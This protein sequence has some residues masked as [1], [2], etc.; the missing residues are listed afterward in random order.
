MLLLDHAA[1]LTHE[2]AKRHL[3]FP[4]EVPPG[5]ARLRIDMQYAPRKVEGQVATN[6]LSLTLFDPNGARGAGHHRLDHRVE[7]SAAAATPGY[8]PG[9]L[10]VGRWLVVVDTHMI[11]PGPVVEMRLT[12]EVSFEPVAAP[13]PSPAPRR[14][15]GR[16]PGWYRGDLHGHTFH[17]DG[18]W[19]V[20]DLVAAARA[21]GLDFVT[22]SDHNTVSGL[23][24]MDS[25]GDN[26]LL[27]MGGMELTTYY[28]HALALGVREWIDWRIRPGERTMEDIAADVRR[29]SGTF[30]IAHPMAPG[31]PICTGCNWN[32]PEMMPGSARIV[33]IWNGGIWSRED[34]YN[35]RGLRLWYD[36][37]N[38]G[39]RMVA[40]AG[41]DIH[42]FG[43]LEDVGMAASAIEA[44]LNVVY[45][46]DL[47]EAA[48]LA[49]VQRG[50]LYL[51]SGPALELT[52]ESDGE[53]TAMMGDAL[54]TARGRVLARWSNCRP[55]DTV[56][57]I[58]DGSSV[59][60]IS[61]TESGAREWEL[62][63]RGWCALEARAA[64]GDLRAITNPIFFAH[65]D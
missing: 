45:A 15:G 42:G 23:A 18:A 25:L 6:E 28:G 55:T 3:E 63:G 38:Q 32:Y 40:T 57:L 1:R 10:P 52:A 31:D 14:A 16:G 8:V 20:P 54:P 39:Y 41:T 47:T 11:L 22:L 48:I 60:A 35:E 61:G 9:P 56:R 19:D 59:E 24:Q 2:H 53:A 17:S 29:R 21:A 43:G 33:E 65:T 7:L 64:N 34:G 58:V 27:T 12:A 30:I 13:A 37:L 36:W 51:S 26:A 46:E 5:A 4:F 44:G 49:A 62:S 50:H